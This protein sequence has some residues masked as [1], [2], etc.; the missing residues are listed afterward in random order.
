MYIKTEIITHP[1]DKQ[2]AVDSTVSFTCISSIS[3][4]ITFSWTLNG[5]SITQLSLTTDDTSIIT[6]T[7][8]SNS[9]TGGY[10]CNVSSGPLS[11]MSNTAILT[12]Y[13]M[14]LLSLI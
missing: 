3:S 11:V 5:V 13:G 8:V 7:R 14:V 4:N 6:I 10:M 2:V 9:D 1:Q 12:V